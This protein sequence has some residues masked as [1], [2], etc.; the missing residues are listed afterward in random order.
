MKHTLRTQN[1]KILSIQ[2][3]LEYQIAKNSDLFYGEICRTKLNKIVTCMGNIQVPKAKL[4]LEVL[5]KKFRPR[6]NLTTFFL[7][8]TYHTI[9]HKNRS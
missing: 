2:L 6:I 1:F 3:S 7:T 8:K 9:Y 4:R 5:F